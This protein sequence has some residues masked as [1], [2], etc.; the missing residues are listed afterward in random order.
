MYHQPQQH[1]QQ[2]KHTHT[3]LTP[4]TYLQAQSLP[5]SNL[6]QNVQSHSQTFLNA[7]LLSNSQSNPNTQYHQRESNGKDFKLAKLVNLLQQFTQ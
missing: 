2:I 7:Q 3:Q 5:Q 6:N 1:S 4:V